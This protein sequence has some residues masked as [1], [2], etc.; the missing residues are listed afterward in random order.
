VALGAQSAAG[1][2]TIKELS[3]ISLAGCW[4]RSESLDCTLYELTEVDLFDN[5]PVHAEALEPFRAPFLTFF[6]VLIYDFI[7]IRRAAPT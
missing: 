7:S 3:F 4:K 2:A 5:F 6:P 1:A